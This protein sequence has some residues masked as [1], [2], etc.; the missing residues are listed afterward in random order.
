MGRVRIKVPSAPTG[1]FLLRVPPLPLLTGG[2]EMG[3]APR[4]CGESSEG[5]TFRFHR[6]NKEL[7]LR[8]RD[9]GDEVVSPTEGGEPADAR[10]LKSLD[11]VIPGDPTRAD[12]IER[13]LRNDTVVVAELDGRV[14][15]YGVLNHG[16]FRQSQV[17]MLMVHG[18]S[19]FQLRGRGRGQG[20]AGCG[21]PMAKAPAGSRTH[22]SEEPRATERHASRPRRHDNRL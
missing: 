20:S 7:H 1:L 4:A 17:E 19:S 18:H 5:K 16:F 13:W 14:A 3:R 2:V 21:R 11:S 8:W 22:R 6:A 10:A 9:G 15:G 12:L